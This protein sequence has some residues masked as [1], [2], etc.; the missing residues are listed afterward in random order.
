MPCIRCWSNA[1]NDKREDRWGIRYP[2]FR[3]VSISTD[4][5]HQYSAF[6]RDISA[7]GIGLL[8]N[9]DLPTGDV[10]INITSG[11]GYAVRMAHS[12]QLVPVVRRRVVHQRRTVRCDSHRGRAITMLRSA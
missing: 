7:S 12:H 1:R 3:A 10:D 4:C 5:G 2:F 8:H 11:R 9:V 6:S